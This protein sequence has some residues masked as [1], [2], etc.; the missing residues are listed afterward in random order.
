[1]AKRKPKWQK[2]MDAGEKALLNRDFDE[3]LSL[4]EQALAL[5]PDNPELYKWLGRVYSDQGDEEQAEQYYRIS[6]EK[7]PTYWASYNN[8]GVIYKNRGLY[9]QALEFFEQ[10]K[11]LNPDSALPIYGLGQIFHLQNNTEM[12]IKYYQIAKEKDP[13]CWAF[14]LELGNLFLE[15]RQQYEHAIE[16]FQKALD[17]K[18]ESHYPY[19]GLGRSHLKLGQLAESEHFFQLALEKISTRLEYYYYHIGEE[20]K[21][22][23]YPVQAIPYFEKASSLSPKADHYHIELSRVYQQLKDYAKAIDYAQRAITCNPWSWYSYYLLGGSFQDL[24]VW[25]KAIYYYEKA[26]QIAKEEDKLYPGANLCYWAIYSDQGQK[27]EGYVQQFLQ[28]EITKYRKI[29]TDLL[30]D[31]AA[32]ARDCDAEEISSR[33]LARALELAPNDR[34]TLTQN[35]KLYQ[36]LNDSKQAESYFLRAIEAN[37]KCVDSYLNLAQLYINQGE[38]VKAAEQCKLASIASPEQLEPYLKLAEIYHKLGQLAKAYRYF[39][40]GLMKQPKNKHLAFN[41]LSI[42]EQQGTG[43]HNRASIAHLLDM[44]RTVKPS[45]SKFSK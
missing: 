7:D 38:L 33:C 30:L 20:Y 14:Y 21:K 32:Y 1:M 42:H 4:F 43:K 8:L 36:D 3:A 39:C 41:K 29:Y 22:N 2:L 26:F 15:K 9:E 5:A 45:K 28:L 6:I 13:S 24:R 10:A 18:P 17:L 16:L 19:L 25:K 37:P 44:R 23:N 12:A 27:A 11:T 40:K 31:I 34:E 35:G